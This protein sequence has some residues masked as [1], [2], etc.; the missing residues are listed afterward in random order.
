MR[1]VKQI[2][3]NVHDYISK[4]KIK[5]LR[6]IW[7]RTIGQRIC[8]IGDPI[9][10]VY[11]FAHIGG[12]S[13][14]GP[15][16]A[17]NLNATVEYNGGKQIIVD[18]LNACD[19]KTV[20]N[21]TNYIDICKK[22]R[23]VC[24]GHKVA[25]WNEMDYYDQVN[26]DEEL[27]NNESYIISSFGLGT[28]HEGFSDVEKIVGKE[29]PIFVDCQNP[30]E[31]PLWEGKDCYLF[32]TRKEIES[33]YI[34]G[35]SLKTFKNIIVKDGALG[36]SFDKESLIAFNTNPVD[37]NGSGD[38]FLAIASMVL[39]LDQSLILEACLLASIASAIKCTKMGNQIITR[40]EIN[41][42]LDFS[43]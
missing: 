7:N 3:R 30:E 25:R 43:E 34:L 19:V 15:L 39:T 9:I 5:E 29:A 42:V 37:T 36:C 33:A 4:E 23:I 35:P 1:K 38:C 8:V 17:Y 13:H 41:Q 2:A 6:S 18:I 28:V 12:I 31:I 22:H 10:D 40:D 14:D 32:A 24:D 16:I 20:T 21:E 11:H 26:L 27:F